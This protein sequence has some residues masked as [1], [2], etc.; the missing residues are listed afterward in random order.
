MIA[1]SLI[2]ESPMRLFI[3]GEEHTGN[4]S[5][6]YSVG[7][8]LRIESSREI[9]IEYGG[10]GGI[11]FDPA[12]SSVGDGEYSC[13]VYLDGD[14][15]TSIA[16]TNGAPVSNGCVLTLNTMES[17]GTTTFD[18]TTLD[19]S[20]GTHTVTAKAKADGFAESNFS[21]EASYTKAPPAFNGSV[22]NAA[23]SAYTLSVVYD[24]SATDLLKGKSK[25][26]AVKQGYSL[27]VS[28]AVTPAGGF[29]I[30]QKNTSYSKVSASQYYVTPTAD[31]WYATFVSYK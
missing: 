25:N 18:L 19:L 30:S 9:K 12:L 7:S 14:G 29:T 10:I 23:A 21:N 26:Y 27:K 22:S 13:N 1:N 4:Y 24:G 2:S 31:N 5:V 15:D 16:L 3:N 20:D 6:Y 8:T 28:V 11:S 17:L